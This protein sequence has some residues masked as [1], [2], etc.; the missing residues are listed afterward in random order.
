MP[1]YEVTLQSGQVLEID[2]DH[3]PTEQEVM[4]HMFPNAGKTQPASTQQFAP[5]PDESQLGP[6]APSTI[7]FVKNIGS[8]LAGQAKAA[9]KSGVDRLKAKDFSAVGATRPSDVINLVKSRATADTDLEQIYQHPAAFLEDAAMVAD[10]APGVARGVNRVAGGG[11]VGG[12]ALDATKAIAKNVP[13]V[14]PAVKGAATDFMASRAARAAKAASEAA[15]APGL[16]RFMPNTPAPS[17]EVA[18]PATDFGPPELDRFMPNTGAGGSGA[19]GSVASDRIPYG[20]SG[21]EAP[22][23]AVDNT[24]GRMTGASAPSVEDVLQQHLEE[25]MGRQGDPAKRMNSA[26][27]TQPVGGGAT[28][29]SG[30]FS[31]DDSVGQAGGYTSGR[32][33]TSAGDWIQDEEGRNIAP[34]PVGEVSDPAF[35][36]HRESSRGKHGDQPVATPKGADPISG[37]QMYD[38]AGGPSH[39]ST[40]SEDQL[41]GLGARVPEGAT[42]PGEVEMRAARDAAQARQQGLVSQ[43]DPEVAMEP[44]VDG[45]ASDDNDTVTGG[46][47]GAPAMYSQEQPWHSG[48]T[49][50][51]ADAKQASGLHKQDAEMDAIYRALME[52]PRK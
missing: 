8:D 17:R 5:K 9:Y 44:E 28:K 12:M 47:R 45:Q 34:Q 35:D 24:G 30:T 51:S 41:A 18:P 33:A 43:V 29:Q 40:V 26:P 50:G 32:P 15:V 22:A 21:V 2:A 4:E 14:G 20:P 1:T 38:I 19:P 7:G 42:V 37:K 49:P 25:E 31:S 23:G 6:G 52:D 36:A 10:A 39:G 46:D 16:E 3:P 13:I 48:A 27:D 11:G